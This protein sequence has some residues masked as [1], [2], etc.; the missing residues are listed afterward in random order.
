M[1]PHIVAIIAIAA[2]ILAI[3]GFFIA[4]EFYRPKPKPEPPAQVSASMMNSKP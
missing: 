4:R 3:A 1:K 2:F